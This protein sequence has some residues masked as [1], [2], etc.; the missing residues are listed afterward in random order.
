MSFKFMLGLVVIFS[1]SSFASDYQN[2]QQANEEV[3]NYL[4]N[5]KELLIGCP[6]TKLVIS[7][8]NM[9]CESYKGENLENCPADCKENVS[10][11]SYNNITLC[12]GY[13]ATQVPHNEAEV[14]DII[15]FAAHNNKKVKAIGASHS[16]TEI[17]CS[18][19]VL[20]PM[21]NL[22]KVFGISKINNNLVVET[23]TG[24]TIFA[25]SEWLFENGYALEGLP[26]MGFRDVTVGGAIAT[27]SHGSSPKH[28]AVISNIIEAIEFIDGEGTTHYLER[29]T[30]DTS[31]FKA[32][33]ASLGLVGIVTKVKL[34]IQKKFNLDVRISYHHE[35]EI[36]KQGLIKQVKECDY[37]QLNWFPG[38]KKFMRT[39][40]VKTPKAADLDADNELLKPRIPKFIVN[41]F[42]KVL[43]YGA[44][45]NH[46][47]SLVE[48]A[49]WWQFKIQPPLVKKNNRGKKINSHHVIGPVH[50]MISSHLIKE[51]EG[52]FQMDWEIAVP[53]S[54]AQEALLAI[55]EHMT[56][57][58]TRLPLVGVFIRFAPSEDKSLIGHTYA[59]NIDWME[60]E[61][62]V[63]FEMPVY[64][65]VGFSP[66]RFANYERQFVEFTQ[67]M[68]QEFSGRPHW[69]KNREWAFEFAVKNKRYINRIEQF[70]KVMHTYDPQGLFRNEFARKN[71]G[72]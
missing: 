6:G 67:M 26:N 20:V 4:Y 54:R 9:L 49:R 35:N 63:F 16:A 46:L 33:S 60:G 15:K 13:T 68:I 66:E 2:Y 29:Q 50:R 56:K 11:R 53:A 3:N 65:P 7:C 45:N 5:T 40:G 72:I 17:M 25:L 32:L 34:R 28:T 39:C 64:V 30:A 57:N 10:V 71:F 1:S 24:I 27:A 47:M 41:P 42:K 19:G 52:F 43:Q 62:A 59:D 12:D 58:F 18:Q 38:V 36:L 31:E 70:Q 23:Q 8:G 55:R 51:Q 21:E 37:G 22:N 44:C 61:P 14:A 48:K 69:G